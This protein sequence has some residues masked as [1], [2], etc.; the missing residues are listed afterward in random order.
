MM[1]T[2]RSRA[3]RTIALVAALAPREL[4][5][6]Y[7]R[8]KLDI[9]WAFIGPVLTLAVYGYVLTSSFRVAVACGTYVTSAWTGLV[10]WTFAAT[11][12][13][14]ATT[15]LVNASAIVTKI[16]FPREVMPLSMT[17]SASAE[18]AIGLVS[19]LILAVVQGVGVSM[20]W[21]AL[22]VPITV[23]MIWTAALSV[24]LACASVF[25]RDTVHAVQLV[26][27]LGFFATPVMYEAAQ[28]PHAFAWSARFNPLAASIEAARASLLCGTWPDWQLM[29][30]HAVG[31]IVAFVAALTY[32]RRR[33]PLI[34]DYL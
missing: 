29:A 23:V 15:S 33:E 7:S 32:L 18:L 11:A 8:S 4:R 2:Q 24:A 21:L 27:R 28:L 25:V 22:L 12:I 10:L 17:A 20:T 5:I 3:V 19:L 1:R 34:A 14:A 16:Y 6:R 30:L 9:A 31:G 13:S 26:I